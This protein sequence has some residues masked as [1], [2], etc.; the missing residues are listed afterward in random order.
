MSRPRIGI[1]VGFLHADPQ[2]RLFKG[3]TLQFVEQQMADA[4]WK[5]GGLP[6]PL[7]DL[8]EPGFAEAVTEPLDGLLLMGGA[9]VAPETYG[10]SPLRPEWAGDAVRDRYEVAILQAALR[11]GQ[12]VLGICRGIQ[13]MNAALGGTLFQ[14]VETQVEGALAHRDWDNYEGV[15]HGVR[16]EPD[17]WLARR[18]GDRELVVNT[19]HHQSLDRVAEGLKVTAKAPDG[20]VEAVED[21]GPDRWLVGVQWHP[22]WLD[23]SVTGGPHR[24]PGQPIFEAFTQRCR[25]S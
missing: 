2:R 3:K 6:M 16:V 14:D 9:D 17:T 19:I 20:I 12:P 21:V 13:L 22:E 24:S 23:G 8:R 25:S 10:Q 11:R 5:G 18:Y 7:S 1:T 4:V 15:E